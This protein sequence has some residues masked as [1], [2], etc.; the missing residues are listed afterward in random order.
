MLLLQDVVTAI[1]IGLEWH[2]GHPTRLWMGV[3]PSY[4]GLHR[5]DL[6][7][8]DLIPADPYNKVLSSG[9]PISISLSAGTPHNRA[10]V[11]SRAAGARYRQ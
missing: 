1:G 10:L 3:V 6:P 11:A 9:S 2:G 4:V 8:A 7:P 5:P